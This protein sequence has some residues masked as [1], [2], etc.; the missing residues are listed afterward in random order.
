MKNA[1][2]QMIKNDLPSAPRRCW[3]SHR[4]N[5]EVSPF[6]WRCRATS[7]TAL[8]QAAQNA[9]KL[10]LVFCPT[11]FSNIWGKE[12]KKFQ[13]WSVKKE[14][15]ASNCKIGLIQYKAT[16]LEWPRHFYQWFPNSGLLW[17][18]SS[19][20]PSQACCLGQGS[21]SNLTFIQCTPI[22]QLPAPFHIK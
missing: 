11:D 2:K 9:C 1:T 17:G 12:G 16:T 3:F 18:Q 22:L 5:S 14:R 20:V 21:S 19:A 4:I 10:S 13:R 7:R 15:K 8:R 6:T